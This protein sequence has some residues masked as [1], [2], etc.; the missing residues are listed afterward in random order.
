M[1]LLNFSKISFTKTSNINICEAIEE[2]SLPLYDLSF[3]EDKN[4][5]EA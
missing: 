5:Y 4:K 2:A 3:V 1:A